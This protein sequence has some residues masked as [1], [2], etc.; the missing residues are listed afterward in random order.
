M[1]YIFCSLLYSQN[2]SSTRLFVPTPNKKE[3]AWDCVKEEIFSSTKSGDEENVVKEES[4]DCSIC[5]Q[6]Y[7]EGDELVRLPCGHKFH[8]CLDSWIRI[9][10]NCPYCRRV[11]HV[12]MADWVCVGIFL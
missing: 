4:K 12:R 11:L 5:L 8:V 10:S 6:S 9:R 7:N 2:Q 3:V 1:F